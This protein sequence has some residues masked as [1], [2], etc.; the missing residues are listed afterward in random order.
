MRILAQL[1]VN[2]Y[3]MRAGDLFAFWKPRYY[4][5]S[6][7]KFVWQKIDYSQ[8][9]VGFITLNHGSLISDTNIRIVE[10]TCST[11]AR[12]QKS[13]LYPQTP[14]NLPCPSSISLH[15][16]LNPRFLFY[17]HLQKK[18]KKL[19]MNTHKLDINTFKCTFNIF[20]LRL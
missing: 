6:Q 14:H 9:P 11:L 5:A 1:K 3:L 4:R 20:C 8:F 13:I 10:T 12:Y 15:R 18:K 7:S 2:P 16:H 19:K 17:S